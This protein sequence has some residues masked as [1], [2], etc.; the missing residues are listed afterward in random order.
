MKTIPD[1]IV[2]PEEPL[3]EPP[4][5]YQPPN[6]PT[7]PRTHNPVAYQPALHG[8]SSSNNRDHS[9]YNQ[10]TGPQAPR[11]N[12]NYLPNTSTNPNYF[13][14]QPYQPPTPTPPYPQPSFEANKPRGASYDYSGGRNYDQNRGYDKGRMGYE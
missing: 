10:P 1:S 12:S 3:R 7:A 11:G 4:R 8:R 2:K 5:P 14:K 6:N 9:P 13:P